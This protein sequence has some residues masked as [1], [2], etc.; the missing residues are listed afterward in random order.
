M[1]GGFAI[2]S[3]GRTPPGDDRER[4]R[5]AAQE[6]EGLFIG[7]ML[8]GMQETAVHSDF[9]DQSSAEQIYR[10]LLTDQLA[11]QTATRTQSTLGENLF[12]A[13]CRRLAEQSAAP[14]KG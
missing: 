13:L 5:R 10:S 3:V 12:R 9:A 2:H 1:T 4:L 14:E 6:F 11:K 7:Q 8:K